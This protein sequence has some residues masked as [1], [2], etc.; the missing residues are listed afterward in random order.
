MVAT[1]AKLITKRGKSVVYIK[2]IQGD[3]DPATGGTSTTETST[4]IKALVKDFSRATDGMAFLSGLILSGDKS[5]SI[6]ASSLTD[7]PLPGDRITFDG[8]SWGVQD[9]KTT[10]SGETNIMYDLSVRK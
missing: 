4:T 2:V 1:A 10:S 9:V 5:I 8:F 3:Y 7:P 6:A